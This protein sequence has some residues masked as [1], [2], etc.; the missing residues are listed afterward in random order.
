MTFSL[1]RRWAGLAVLALAP[2]VT[3]AC[4][5]DDSSANADDP[6]AFFDGQ[7]IELVVPFSAGGGYDTTARLIEPYLEDALPGH[8]NIVVTN[9]PGGGGLKG[10]QYA[11]NQDPG[12]V[13]GMFALDKWYTPQLVGEKVEGF[14]YKD[15]DLLGTP[16]SATEHMACARK[17]RFTSWDDLKDS[18]KK[19]KFGG[20]SAPGGTE[21]QAQLLEMGGFP[22]EIVRGYDGV[23][24]IV[25]S[26]AQGETDATVRCAASFGITEYPEVIKDPGLVPLW[27]SDVPPT[28]EYLNELGMDVAPEDIPE[29]TE[30]PGLDLSPDVVD[31][32]RAAARF[33]DFARSMFIHSGVSDAIAEAWHKAFEEAVTDKEFRAKLAKAGEVGEYKSTEEI[34]EAVKL[35]EAL[36]PEGVETFKQF[37]ELPE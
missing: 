26:I 1:R 9:L 37:I 16:N 17:D 11:V 33:D 21:R 18:K 5:G 15:I 34:N 3:T 25:A 20:L 12:K 24:E 30:L 23:E 31:A 4:G 14:D 13:I 19:L 8:P 10:I 36:S 28:A 2:L 7:K 6:A 29:L 27:Y 22:V 32:Y 35:V